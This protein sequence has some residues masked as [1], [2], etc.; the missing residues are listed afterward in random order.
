MNIAGQ[1]ERH[2]LSRADWVSAA[3]LCSAF[4][5]DE[6]QFRQDG[7]LPGLC[8]GYA[9]SGPKGFKHVKS[10]TTAEWL[11]FKHRLRRHGV[12]ELI[13][14]RRLDRARSA[15]KRTITSFVVEADSGQVLMGF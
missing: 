10:A 11:S 3:E 4:S 5:V 2:L 12:Q 6:R 15:L 9:I 8:T 14:V 7:D 1:I 13:R